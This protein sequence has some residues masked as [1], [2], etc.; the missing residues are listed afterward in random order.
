MTPIPVER[1]PLAGAYLARL[2]STGSPTRAS[3]DA[4]TVACDW[5]GSEWLDRLASLELSLG[6][7]WYQPNPWTYQR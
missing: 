3:R 6:G 2:E 7:F 1:Y 4:A 5:L